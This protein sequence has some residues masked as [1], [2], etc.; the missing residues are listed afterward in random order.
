MTRGLDPKTNAHDA[1]GPTTR[2]PLV[3]VVVVNYNYGR[4][5]TDAVTSVFGQTYREVE[6]LVV[7]NASTDES[8][9]VLAA[10][11]ERFTQLVVIERACNDGQTPASLD[12]LRRAKG[13][14]VIFL[15]ADDYLLPQC[16]ETH[17]YAHLSMRMHI[18]LTSAD[19]L[20]VK[21][22]AV[23]VASGEEANRFI[24]SRKGLRP[25]LVR[26]YRA[27][28]DWP[29]ATVRERTDGRLHY[30]PPLS[31]RW[32]WSPT[33]G[34]CYRRDALRLFEDNPQ[35]ASLRTGTDIY[36]AFGCSGLSGSA[37]IDEPLFAY[38]VHGGNIYTSHPQLDRTL[39]FTVGGHGDS[40]TKAQLVLVDHLVT[41]VDRFATNAV[42]TLNFLALL[43]RTDR[44]DP[45]GD[46]PRWARRSRAAQAIVRNFAHF[47][48]VLG[49]PLSRATLVAFSGSLRA[50]ATLAA[51][52]PEE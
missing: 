41:H 40:N 29:S 37:L 1:A 19:M 27:T 34:I 26:P 7:D 18:G 30:V 17:V 45:H 39:N 13:Q 20:Q 6:C 43:A 36:F 14:Y 15:D 21:D 48:R 51:E 12:G 50:P 10:L 33:S 25:E 28:P 24:R 9:E 2:L 46:L 52:L 4:F 47:A 22:D 11:Q 31:V 44:A 5:L 32:V 42:L 35:L 38:R 16:I 3:S 49:A 23:V 8:G